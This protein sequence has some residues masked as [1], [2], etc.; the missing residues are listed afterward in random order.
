MKK[1]EFVNL[2]VEAAEQGKLMTSKHDP[3]E[4]GQFPDDPDRTVLSYDLADNLGRFV[5]SEKYSVDYY[6]NTRYPNSPDLWVIEPTDSE[7]D[8]PSSGITGDS[9]STAI[10]LDR[11]V[12][13]SGTTQGI[14]MYGGASAVVRAQEQ[15]GTW[16]KLERLNDYL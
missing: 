14:H 3:D 12:V 2:L 15:R 7:F 9:V 6:E 13:V 5:R 8:I 10:G 11:L 1:R 16:I 4:I